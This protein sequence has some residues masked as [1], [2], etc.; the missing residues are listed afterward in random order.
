[1]K[2]LHQIKITITTITIYIYIYIQEHLHCNTLYNLTYP[3]RDFVDIVSIYVLNM[4]INTKLIIIS[5]IYK[6]PNSTIMRLMI[7]YIILVFIH[8]S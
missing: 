6:S 7:L 8:K 4:L 3:M 1:M 2:G 5:E